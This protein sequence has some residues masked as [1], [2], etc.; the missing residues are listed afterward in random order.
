MNILT[1]YLPGNISTWICTAP[2]HDSSNWDKPGRAA[3]WIFSNPPPQRCIKWCARTG[4]QGIASLILHLK[5]TNARCLEGVF[6]QKIAP[7]ERV[8]KS[9]PM[10]GARLSQL[11]HPTCSLLV[12]SW[13]ESCLTVVTISRCT[14]EPQKGDLFSLTVSVPGKVRSCSL[15]KRWAEFFFSPTWTIT[16]SCHL[17]LWLQCLW[18]Q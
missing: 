3:H 6:Q 15:L 13:A 12:C 7:H 11:R 5:G 18:M 9:P 1:H 16:I 2:K 14:S 4:F 10:P 8:I 17:N